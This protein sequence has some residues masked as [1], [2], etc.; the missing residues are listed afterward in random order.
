MRAESA[1]FTADYLRKNDPDRYWASLVLP[2]GKRS[3]VQ[4]LYAFS[5]DVAGIRD[6]VSQPMAGEIRLQWW[7]DALEGSGHGD[8]GRNPLAEALL[9]T[10]GAFRLNSAPFIHLVEAR[11]FDLYD[12]PMPDIGTF[13]GYAGETA[14]VLL[15]MA[16]TILNDGKAV[17][18]GDAAGHLGVAQSSV[19]HLRAFGFNA[20]RGRLFVPLEV[21]EANGVTREDVAAGKSS[22]GLVQAL[23][24]FSDLA[25]GHL[26]R[27]NAALKTLPRPVHPAFAISALLQPQLELARRRGSP[28]EAPADLPDWKKIARLSVW[29]LRHG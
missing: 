1:A 21:L 23:H 25:V 16:A 27:A 11:R 20:S 5:A 9:D 26:A 18:P 10:I 19:G 2:A 14:S 4:S 17:E 12:D 3:A 24:Q 22:P 7:K 29:S 8:I 6:R 13:E 28:F 15:Q